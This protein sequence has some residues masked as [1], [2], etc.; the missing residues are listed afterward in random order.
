MSG[1]AALRDGKVYFKP[2]ETLEPNHKITFKVQAKAKKSG[3]HDFRVI[4]KSV[5]PETRLAVQETT[6][7]F[8]MNQAESQ[9]PA[10]GGGD[11]KVA[12]GRDNPRSSLLQPLSFEPQFRAVKLPTKTRR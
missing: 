10:Q 1:S 4:V 7:F 9:E 12:A 11:D 8:D 2:V 6:R 5:V 3:S